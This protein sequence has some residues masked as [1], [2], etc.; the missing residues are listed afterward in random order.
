MPIDADLI[1]RESDLDPLN[2]KTFVVMF[3]FCL[4]RRALGIRFRLRLGFTL[5]RH[6]G[7]FHIYGLM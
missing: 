4:G 3:V 5:L 6:L 7:V 2:P 1:L